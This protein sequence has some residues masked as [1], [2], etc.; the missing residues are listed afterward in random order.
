MADPER[1]YPA[2]EV[3][4]KAAKARKYPASSVPLAPRSSLVS[5]KGDPGRNPG[6]IVNMQHPKEQVIPQRNT[7]RYYSRPPKRRRNICCRCLV[8]TFCLLL[9]FIVAIAIAAGVLYAVFQPGIPKYSVNKIQIT[10]FA[11]GTDD[12]VSS[13]FVVGVQARNPNKKIGIYYLDDSYLAVF[14]SDTELS[15]GSLPA[16]YQ[17]HKNTSDLNVVLTG[18]N[19]QITSE[20][21]SS[22]STQGKDGKIPLLLK[23]DV[24]VKVKFGKLKTMKITFH[25]RCDLLVD[26]LEANTSII[27]SYTNCKLK[28]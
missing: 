23:V 22:L 11:V 26:K 5:E 20:V 7:P 8:W 27:I 13:Q 21:V 25:V 14:Y 6:R 4:E 9:I 15:R 16:F 10:S 28:R 18:T 1:I 2:N 24:P 19:V 3:V 12:T 17:G